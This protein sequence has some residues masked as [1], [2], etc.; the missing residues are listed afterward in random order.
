MTEATNAPADPLREALA[1]DVAAIEHA[2]KTTG[3]V[4]SYLAQ[5]AYRVEAH[6]PEILQALS[7]TREEATCEACDGSGADLYGGRPDRDCHVCNGRKSVSATREE[8]GARYR[9][10]ARGTE[11]TLIGVGRVQGALHDED[12]VV[13]YR[14]DDGG[15]W[16]RHQVEFCDGRFEKIAQ[17]PS[18]HRM[19]ASEAGPAA[20]GSA[21]QSQARVLLN[22]HG[23]DPAEWSGEET[24]RVFDLISAVAN[25]QLPQDFVR[26]IIAARM[27]AWEDP[28]AEN[29]KELQEASE[30]FA[31]RVPWEDEPEDEA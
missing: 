1:A 21:W 2:R 9:H 14:G 4:E 28:D 19:G 25:A 11:Y 15:L 6:L 24:R 5:L 16:V 29:L 18:D 30:A 3:Q 31:S 27:V 7:A 23:T 26:L 12:P 10:K 13:L 22:M 8:G 17:A 20:E